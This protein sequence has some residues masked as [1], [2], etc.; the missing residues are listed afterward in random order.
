MPVIVIPGSRFKRIQF[1][2]EFRPK[3]MNIIAGLLT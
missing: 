1:R 2:L 3:A